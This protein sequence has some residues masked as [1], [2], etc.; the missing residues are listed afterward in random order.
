[1]KVLCRK[2]NV[3]P[4][5]V[6]EMYL[7]KNCLRFCADHLDLK[8]WLPLL[9]GIMQDQSLYKIYVYSQCRRKK[10]REKMDTEE[11]LMKLR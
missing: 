3:K 8:D 10:I 4:L 2:K 7:Q 6:M 1:M 11:K 9:N 5:P